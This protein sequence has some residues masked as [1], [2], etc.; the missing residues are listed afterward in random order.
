MSLEDARDRSLDFGPVGD[1]AP[2]RHGVAATAADLAG[3][4]LEPIDPPG[5]ERHPHAACG[6][7][8]A[9][10]SSDA[11]RGAGDD[12]DRAAPVSQS[13]HRTPSAPGAARG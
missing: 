11:A 10:L 5:E 9:K 8:A 6:E 12:P 7:I 13:G 3:E 2:D 4:R 1:V